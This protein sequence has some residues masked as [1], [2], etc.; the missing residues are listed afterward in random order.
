MPLF[1]VFTQYYNRCHS[2][3]DKGLKPLAG[4]SRFNALTIRAIAITKIQI[5]GLK[6]GN[7]LLFFRNMGIFSHDLPEF[8][9]INGFFFDEEID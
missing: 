5:N 2:C 6:L 1:F 7:K 9:A 8:F 4:S 3:K